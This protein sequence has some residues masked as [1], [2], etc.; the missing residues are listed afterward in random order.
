[1]QLERLSVFQLRCYPPGGAHG[2]QCLAKAYPGLQ[3]VGCVL[4][5]RVAERGFCLLAWPHSAAGRSRRFDE[6][7]SFKLLVGTRY[8]SGGDPQITGKLTDRGELATGF[9]RTATDQAEKLP[10]N[11]LI[12]RGRVGYINSDH[13]LTR[14]VAICAVA[15]W[16][17]TACGNPN[18]RSTASVNQTMLATSAA[19]PSTKS[20]SPVICVAVETPG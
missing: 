8:G 4:F 16:C 5:S 10:A 9:E 18:A 15:A 11:L 7:G 2:A 20:R 6:S 12:G 19:I 3:C 14:P 13:G 17:A 1:M